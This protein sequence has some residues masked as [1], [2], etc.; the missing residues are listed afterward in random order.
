MYARFNATFFS[1]SVHGMSN[2]I[3]LKLTIRSIISSAAVVILAN[4][5]VSPEISSQQHNIPNAHFMCNSAY[6]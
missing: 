2:N 5:N 6:I 3:V 4:L 1:L